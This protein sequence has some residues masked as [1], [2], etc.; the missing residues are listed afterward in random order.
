ML[1]VVGRNGIP[2]PISFSDAFNFWLP[3]SL[4]QPLTALYYVNDEPASDLGGWFSEVREV[5]RIDD[6]YAREYGTTIFRYSKPIRPFSEF[7]SQR[8]AAKPSPY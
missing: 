1:Q 3:D 7:W 6:P 4:P 2:E 8:I 5:G